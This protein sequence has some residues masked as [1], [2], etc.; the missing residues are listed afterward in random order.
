LE[1]AHDVVASLSVALSSSPFVL[2]FLMQVR[3]FHYT[4]GHHAIGV[5]A[6]PE[7]GMSGELVRST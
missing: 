3:G 5:V 2:K 1:G 4:A 6:N 7:T